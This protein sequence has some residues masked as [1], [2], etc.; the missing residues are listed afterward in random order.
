MQKKS[1]ETIF[2]STVGIAIMVVLLVAVNY[3]AGA[4]RTRGDLTQEKAYTFQK[5]RG[6]S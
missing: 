1:L 2:Y 3:I 6:R 5:G 4:V